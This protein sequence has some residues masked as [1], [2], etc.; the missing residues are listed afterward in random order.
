[1]NTR[2]KWLV[3]GGSIAAVVL[4]SGLAFAASRDHGY[5]GGHG[6]GNGRYGMHQSEGDRGANSERRS[7]GRG[8]QGGRF[9]E[10]RGREHHGM[11]GGGQGHGEGHGGRQGM[12]RDGDEGGRG[13]GRHMDGERH[14]DNRSG[15]GYGRNN[16]EGP[17]FRT[18]QRNAPSSTEQKTDQPNANQDTGRH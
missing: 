9:N 1:M 4:A 7:E 2:T 8:D 12:N 10:G 11:R 6:G 17:R 5:G 18:E 13:M 14:R 15:F 3:G 16:D